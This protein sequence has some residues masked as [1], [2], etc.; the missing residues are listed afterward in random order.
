MSQYS[1]QSSYNTLE[2]IYASTN[3]N[4]S[5]NHVSMSVSQ[6]IYLTHYKKTICRVVLTS[7]SVDQLH[8]YKVCYI[9]K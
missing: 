3:Y 8:C 5:T 6:F 2:H 1:C 9:D 4:A 7:Y